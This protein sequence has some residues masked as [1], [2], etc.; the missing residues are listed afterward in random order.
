MFSFPLKVL[1]YAEDFKSE[2]AD[3]ER[4]QGQIEDLKEKISQL[5]QQLH[6]QVT[7]PSYLSDKRFLDA[8]FSQRH[9]S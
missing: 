6:K 8:P 5:K 2:R 4:A 1:I 3:R 7:S 9:R